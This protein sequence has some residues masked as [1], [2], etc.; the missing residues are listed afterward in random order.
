VGVKHDS[1]GN[2]TYEVKWLGF[3]HDRNSFESRED[4]IAD[5]FEAA[6]TAYEQSRIGLPKVLNVKKRRARSQTPERTTTRSFEA[7][8]EAENL[9]DDEG[10][11]TEKDDESQ[12]AEEELTDKD[13]DEVDS[14]PS[15]SAEI[16]TTY[17]SVKLP[18]EY[19]AFWGIALFA[20][21]LMTTI[22]K[23]AVLIMEKDNLIIPSK[24]LR[25]FALSSCIP[26]LLFL[27]AVYQKAPD[28]KF[29]NRACALLLW[30]STVSFF[31][32]IGPLLPKG[33]KENAQTLVWFSFGMWQAMLLLCISA[34]ASKHPRYAFQSITIG[35]I[36]AA[37]I[38][39]YDAESRGVIFVKEISNTFLFTLLVSALSVLHALLLLIW[40]GKR[41]FGTWLEFYG[42]LGSFLVVGWNIIRNVKNLFVPIQVF[43]LPKL[44]QISARPQMTIDYLWLLE[45]LLRW[46]IA[47]MFCY[48]AVNYHVVIKRK[49]E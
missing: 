22:F 37:A 48:S 47:G 42:A 27:A 28:S 19:W 13:D 4:L 33:E 45:T 7:L 14:A 29:S 16:A 17:S 35:S 20:S 41:N 18:D 44:G 23:M 40:N 36:V 26:Y 46:A 11:E 10:N 8:K 15:P 39:L 38:Y 12:D 21:M 3:S 9:G 2:L 32:D 1:Q 25:Y 49:T 30:I 6:V 5:G 34:S 24:E 43:T 31:E